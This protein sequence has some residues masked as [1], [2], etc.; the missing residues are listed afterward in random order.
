MTNSQALAGFRLLTATEGI[1]PALET[2]HA[3]WHAVQ[4]AGSM[5][6]DQSI[7]ICCSGRGDKDLDTALN[8]IA[9][10]SGDAL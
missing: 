3:V 6:A 8:A 2:S 9:A 1:I 10:G 5:P 4:M 7:V